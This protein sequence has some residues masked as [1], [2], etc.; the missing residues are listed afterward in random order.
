[1]DGNTSVFDG[2][3][4]VDGETI[5]YVG[6]EKPMDGTVFDREIDCGGDLLLPGFK[7]AHA[8]SAG[9]FLR[10]YADDL[11]LKEW[12]F[13]FM[14][15]NESRLTPEA[16]YML[17]RLAILEYLS[18]GITCMSDMYY[19]RATVARAAADSGFRALVMD[20]VNDFGG[21][22]ERTMREREETLACG[23]LVRHAV[24][25]HAEYTTSLPLLKEIATLVNELKEPCYIH[26]NETAAEVDGCVERHG[27]RPFELMDELGMFRYGGVGYHCVHVSDSELAIM[28]RSGIY[29]V[30][31]PGSNCK[32]GSGIA[33]IQRMLALGIPIAIGTD[34]AASNNALDMFREMHLVTVLQKLLHG[35]DAA[36]ANEV[37]RMACVNGAYACGFPD[38]DRLAAGKQADVVRI[39]L[40]QPNMQPL[41]NIAKNVVFSGSKRNVRMTMVAGKVLYEDGEYFIGEAP[42]RIYEAANAFVRGC[43]Q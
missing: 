19:F 10:S 41:R 14:I 17:T 11:P 36:D 35:A 7:N 6:T 1:M 39:D 12:L 15:P 16:A 37:L 5:A 3:L 43:A 29:A 38:C 32:L 13:D 20:G 21:S 24:S 23:P 22:A 27:V 26:M 9:V 25:V 2:E 34:S 40:R 31:C 28:K 18:S 30:T 33:P 4:H 8:H 42:E